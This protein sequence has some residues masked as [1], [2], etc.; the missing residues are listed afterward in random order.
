MINDIFGKIERGFGLSLFAY[1]GAIWKRGCNVEFVL[2]QIQRALMSVEELG[3][4]GGSK[5]SA[6]KTNMLYVVLKES[7]LI[8]GYGAV[9]YII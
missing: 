6:P 4:T 3:S 7:Y 8:Q 9:R 2:K 5:I 1:I